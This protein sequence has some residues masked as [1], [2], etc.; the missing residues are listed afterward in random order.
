M[1]LLNRLIIQEGANIMQIQA[2]GIQMNFELTGKKGAPVVALSHSLGSGLVMWDPQMAGLEQD[3]QVLRY[4]T[5]GHGKSEAPAG[6]YT[7][8]K[9]GEDAIELL[10]VLDIDKVHWVGLSM[11]GMIGQCLALDHAARLQS[12]VLCDT[13][14]TIPREAQPI[15]QER[16]DAV[17]KKGMQDQVDGTM[18]RWFTPAY[19]N[20]NPPEA[21]V[22]HKQFINTPVAGYIGCSEAIRMLDYLKRLSAI[23]T[24]TLIMVGEDDPGTP[25]AAAK[26]MHRRIPASRLVVLPSAAHLSN[27]EQSEAFNRTL[28][29]FLQHQR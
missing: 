6:A 16:I 19:L 27:V 29:S 7:L 8:Q 26:A 14:A 12:L 5:R 25:V 10:G 20:Q 18:A 13:A 11:G 28:L 4:D 17:S 9:L 15:W 22:I 21:A 24:P 2:N 1:C 3:Y 23:K